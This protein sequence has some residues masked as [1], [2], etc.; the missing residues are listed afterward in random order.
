MR[1]TLRDDIA[2]SVLTFGDETDT[3]RVILRVTVQPL[4][5]WLWLGGI[6]MA[7]GTVLSLL[8]A[9]SRRREPAEAAAAE[10]PA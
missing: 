4:V 7:L 1:S 9:G 6:V 3:D 10:V 8:P 2:L 5:A